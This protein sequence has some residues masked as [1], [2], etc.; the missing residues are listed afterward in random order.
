[1]KTREK[2]RG[3]NLS[4]FPNPE[5]LSPF[6]CFLHFV[7]LSRLSERHLYQVNIDMT[8]DEKG[9]STEF[10]RTESTELFRFY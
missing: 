4:A 5:S 7:L 2:E 10:L 3:P 8:D 6:P 1:M 9:A